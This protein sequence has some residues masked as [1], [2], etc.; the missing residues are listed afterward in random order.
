MYS[1]V[2]AA[3][4]LEATDIWDPEK[5]DVDEKAAAGEATARRLTAIAAM[6][7]MVSKVF[8]DVSL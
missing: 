8:C 4:F 7:F 5:E 3:S 2:I 1:M 6:D